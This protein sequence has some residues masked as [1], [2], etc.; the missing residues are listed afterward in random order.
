[1]ART[2]TLLIHAARNHLRAAST[3][4]VGTV[5]FLAYTDLELKACLAACRTAGLRAER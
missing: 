4:R 5:L 2:A 3:S 1:M